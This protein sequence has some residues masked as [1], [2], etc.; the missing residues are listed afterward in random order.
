[1][2]I[3]KNGKIRCV[4]STFGLI[5]LLGTLWMWFKCRRRYRY[6]Q[7]SKFTTVCDDFFFLHEIPLLFYLNFSC[8]TGFFKNLIYASVWSSWHIKLKR[9]QRTAYGFWSE[10]D[11]HNNPESLHDV[12]KQGD[13][14]MR[15]L[16]KDEVMILD[17]SIQLPLFASLSLTRV[18]W[19][20]N[21]HLL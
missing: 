10:R 21:T 13:I 16:K 17:C 5:F 20:E 7:R 6:L 2:T 14:F 19:W 15:T 8:N 9:F 1:M 11:L 18:W 12:Y 4:C 3:D